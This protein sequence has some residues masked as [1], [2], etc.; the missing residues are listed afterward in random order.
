MGVLGFL[1][2]LLVG[3]VGTWVLLGGA[4]QG[5]RRLSIAP[6]TGKADPAAGSV[7]E[8]RRLHGEI[9]DLRRRLEAAEEA[10]ARAEAA[11][12]GA[13]APPSPE[14]APGPTA[15]VAAGSSDAADDLT[16]I[17]GVGPKL[18]DKLHGLGI[19]TYRQIADL[20][21]A[22]IARIDETLNFRG[23]IEREAWVDQAKALVGN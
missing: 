15:A 21:A 5:R 1:I 7:E 6:P 17:K 14:P 4:G 8:M 22:D 9:A 16:K 11:L 18:Q 2:G 23:R 19:R 13:G 20:T 3:A 10:R 12:A